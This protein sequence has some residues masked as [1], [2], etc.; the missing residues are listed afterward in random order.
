M[1][2]ALVEAPS[3]LIAWGMIDLLINQARQATDNL[4]DLLQGEEYKW[5]REG[6]FDIVVETQPGNGVCKILSHALQAYFRTVGPGRK[7]H[8]MAPNN[9]LRFD[10]EIYDRVRPT[11]HAER[12]IVSMQVVERYIEERACVAGCVAGGGA[13]SSASG[14]SAGT[15][16]AASAGG[17]AATA[18]YKYYASRNPKQQTDLADAY[19]QAC[20]E[21]QVGPDA[22]DESASLSQSF[23]ASAKAKRRGK[24]QYRPSHYPEHTDFVPGEVRYDFAS[25]D[26]DFL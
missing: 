4:I 9:K 19:I 20:R 25:E 18:L 11:S 16:A 22:C 15:S 1:A 13:S 5:I 6:T 7:F 23:P 21:I 12:K 8:F 26:V 24:P 10:T 14:V 2:F 3:T 17:G